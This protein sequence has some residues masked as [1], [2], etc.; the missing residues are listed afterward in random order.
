MSIDKLLELNKKQREL[1][2][3]YKRSKAIEG[4]KYHLRR[5]TVALP[6]RFMLIDLSTH[7]IVCFGPIER[8]NSYINLRKGK[9]NH[10]F[11]DI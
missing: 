3:E 11:I 1:L 4:C 8:I 5:D 6:K 10:I 2:E 7:D 9:I